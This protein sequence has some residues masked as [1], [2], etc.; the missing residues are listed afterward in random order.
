MG[1][2]NEDEKQLNKFNNEIVT[3]SIAT[4]PPGLPLRE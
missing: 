1:Q 2:I 3:T 4:Y